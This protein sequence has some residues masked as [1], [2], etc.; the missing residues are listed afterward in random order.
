M[1]ET[2]TDTFRPFSIFV[3]CLLWDLSDVIYFFSDFGCFISKENFSRNWFFISFHIV[4]FLVDKKYSQSFASSFRQKGKAL[5]FICSFVTPWGCI[6]SQKIWNSLK[7]GSKWINIFFF[8]SNVLFVSQYVMHSDCRVVSSAVKSL[9]LGVLWL[10]HH[11][12]LTCIFFRTL[13]SWL[14][15]FNTSWIILWWFEGCRGLQSIK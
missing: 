12:D 11:S 15:V 3:E 9:K 4:K 8:N 10:I 2:C 1:R 7:L 5:M 14:C 6:P 13:F